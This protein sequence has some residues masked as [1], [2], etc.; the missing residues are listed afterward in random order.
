M[1]EVSPLPQQPQGPSFNFCLIDPALLPEWFWVPTGH[2][3][4]EQGHN[5]YIPDLRR[6]DSSVGVEAKIDII[7]DTMKGHDMQ[8]VVALSRGVEFAV[9]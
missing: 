6:G 4:Q 9:R 5:Y 8:Y 7:E 2:K 3:L 1:S